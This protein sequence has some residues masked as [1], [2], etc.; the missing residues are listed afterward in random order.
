MQSLVEVVC[1]IYLGHLFASTYGG[2]PE[3]A[4]PNLKPDFVTGLAPLKIFPKFISTILKSAFATGFES[5]PNGKT[6]VSTTRIFAQLSLL[7]S[8]PH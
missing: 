2:Y 7:S 4:V 5:L 1:S 3:A 6:P 8:S